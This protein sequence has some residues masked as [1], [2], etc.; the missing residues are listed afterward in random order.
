[1]DDSKR[2]EAECDLVARCL[3]GSSALEFYNR[4]PV[5]CNWLEGLPEGHLRKLA[6]DCSWAPAEE[7]LGD[8]LK[9]RSGWGEAKLATTT[10][11]LQRAVSGPDGWTVRLYLDYVADAGYIAL[12]SSQPVRRTETLTDRINLDYG[13]DG[14]MIG[15]EVLGI[16]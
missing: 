5:I 10:E 4:L 1:M 2:L 9:T 15:I 13:A 6:S 12:A 7:A 3:F 16:S 11:S 14:A 8:L